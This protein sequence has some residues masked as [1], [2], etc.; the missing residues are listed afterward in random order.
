MVQHRRRDAGLLDDVVAVAQYADPAQIHLHRPDRPPA[1][2]QRGVTGI[3]GDAV[4]HAARL[5]RLRIDPMRPP[6]DDLGR[7]DDVIDGGQ[8]VEYRAIRALQALSHDEAELALQPRL[9]EPVIGI[10]CPVS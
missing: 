7:G 1:D 5:V 6:I 2:D 3:V 8:H 9:D 4:Q 10:S